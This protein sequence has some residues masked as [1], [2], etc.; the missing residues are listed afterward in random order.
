MRMSKDR[1]E[2]VTA[3]LRTDL[4]VT[5]TR[6]DVALAANAIAT[7]EEIR[8]LRWALRLSQ[9]QFGRRLGVCDAVVQRWERGATPVAPKKPE[10]AKRLGEWLDRM[11]S[12]GITPGSIPESERKRPAEPPIKG[13]EHRPR[14]VQFRCANCGM[15]LSR[16]QLRKRVVRE[17][18]RDLVELEHTAGSGDVCGPVIPH[19]PKVTR[20][21]RRAED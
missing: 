13:P 5:E 18:E 19:D 20:P 11:R 17:G 4:G 10:V 3:R 2:E 12:A 1:W 7:A 8:T 16:I 14:A 21:L 9:V 15:D 6:R